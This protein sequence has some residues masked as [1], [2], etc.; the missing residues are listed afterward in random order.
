MV[1]TRGGFEQTKILNILVLKVNETIKITGF[2]TDQIARVVFLTTS[3]LY[4][5]K[6][7]SSLCY[8]TMWI[9]CG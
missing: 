4:M 9:G 3:C 1:A 2:D 7:A 8:C 5:R 6:L